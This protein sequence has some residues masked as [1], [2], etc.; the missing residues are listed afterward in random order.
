MRRGIYYTVMGT[1][2]IFRHGR[3]IGGRLG[4]AI[5]LFLVLLTRRNS[6]RKK[7]ATWKRKSRKVSLVSTLVATLVSW[8]RETTFC[9]TRPALTC[10][11]MKIRKYTWPARHIFEFI[12]PN[13][14]SPPPSA[15][16]GLFLRE[17]K[18]VDF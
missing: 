10:W 17:T 4:G 3:A 9:L 7:V 6:H 5:I 15:H 1:I 11:A 8:S 13:K 2:A 18:I 14:P 16:L 12:W